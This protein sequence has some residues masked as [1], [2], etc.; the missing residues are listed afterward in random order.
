MRADF[1]GYATKAGLKCSDGRTIMPEAFQHMDGAKVPLVWQHIHNDPTNILGHAILEARSDGV[2]AH[3]YFNDTEKAKSAKALVQHGDVVALSIY[4]NQLVEKS[5]QV[6]HGVIREVSL[7]L[8]GANPGAK[9]ENVTLAHSDGFD[10]FIAD[11]AVIYTGETIQH[12]EDSDETTETVSE[13]TPEKVQEELEHAEEDGDDDTLE[14]VYNSLSEKQKNVVHFM[15]GAALE[16]A[17]NGSAE[18][19][20]LD[21]PE[22]ANIQE[23]YDTLT[24]NQKNVVHFMI[25]AA[26]EAADVAAPTDNPE[27]IAHQEGTD[28]N[29]FEKQ[30]EVTAPSHVLSHSDIAAIVTDGQRRGSL[31]EAVE[32]HALKHGIEDIDVLFPD[33]RAITSTPEFFKRRTEWVSLV[34]D[35]TRH[36][37]FSRIKSLSADLTLEAARAKGYV[38]GSLKKEEFFKVS[39]RVTTPQTIYKKQKLDRDDIVDITDFDVVVWLKA[40]MRLMLEEEV[41][42]AILFG[43]G[44]SIADDDKIKEDNVRSIANDHEFYATTVYVNIDDANSSSDE[45]VDRLTAERRHYRGSGTPTFFTTE[46]ALA[47]LLLAKDTLGRRLYRDER[48]L[49]AVLR[50]DKIVP[51]EAM[52][53]DETLV[54]II[55]NL[56]DYTVGADKGGDV[57]MFDDFDIDYNQHKYLIETRIS[58]AL[59]KPKSALVVRKTAGTNVEVEPQDPTFNEAT[60]VV[61]I[62]AQTGVEYRNAETNAVLTAGAQP[63]LAEG[64]SLMVQANPTAGYFFASNAEDQWVFTNEA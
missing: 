47:N 29:V 25:G 30:N 55:V 58:G 21:I 43:D 9:I 33:A 62:P 27:G 22:D 20:D 63:A 2:Y 45:I 54:G 32:A 37:P 61:T 34:L 38:K 60:G 23:V 39:K 40:E 56:Q 3:A 57:S 10:E 44:R 18:H 35:G 52:E 6:F 1:S 11:E 7:V 49:A 24:D 48:E 36:T 16:A 53:Q 46:E 28:M 42:R 19:S 15:I 51:V 8:S 12:S 64:D 4:A 13:E 50:V 59:T 26:L 5:K 14:D 31:K 17:Q 41:A